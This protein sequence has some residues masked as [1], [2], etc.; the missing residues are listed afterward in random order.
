MRTLAPKRQGFK[1][2]AKKRRGFGLIDVLLAT[3]ILSVGLV[4]TSR[5]FTNIYSQLIPNGEWG[6]LRRYVLAETMLKAQSEGL[7]AMRYVPPGGAACKV[8]TEPVN[9]SYQLNVNQF[10]VTAG[11]NSELYYFDLEMRHHGD[12]VATLSVSTL[13]ST[14]VRQNEKIGL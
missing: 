4:A 1:L 2:E 3:V 8:I 5:F 12:S 7:R 6:G 13:R 14:V 11:T 9:T 10:P